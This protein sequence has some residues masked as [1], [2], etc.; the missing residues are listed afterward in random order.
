VDK[1]IYCSLWLELLFL[2][3]SSRTLEILAELFKGLRQG[4]AKRSVMVAAAKR[5]RWI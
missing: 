2:H 4:L 1:N 5:G 3:P